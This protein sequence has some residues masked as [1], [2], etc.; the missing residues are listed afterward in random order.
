M[1]FFIKFGFLKK[2]EMINYRWT[3][4]PRNTNM[5]V[6]RINILGLTEL[7][8]NKLFS[9]SMKNESYATASEDAVFSLAIN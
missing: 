5:P 9:N 2:S 8:A 6:I 3:V 7:R 1:Y 4:A